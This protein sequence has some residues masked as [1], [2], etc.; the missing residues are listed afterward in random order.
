MSR[1]SADHGVATSSSPSTKI[2][3]ISLGSDVVN[4]VRRTAASRA[5]FALQ[6]MTAISRRTES[7]LTPR[8]DLDHIEFAL[9]SGPANRIYELHEQPISATEIHGAEA[10]DGPQLRLGASPR[11]MEA[12]RSARTSPLVLR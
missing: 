3:P 5:R 11:R 2:T 4:H 6:V 8:L 10:A 12:H 1:S 7:T 9:C